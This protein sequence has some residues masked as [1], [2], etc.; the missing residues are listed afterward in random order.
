MKLSKIK[1]SEAI[2]KANLKIDAFDTELLLSFVKKVNRPYLYTHQNELL[3][4]EEKVYFFDLVQER[5]LKKPLAYLLGKKGFWKNDFYLD[6]SV[7]VPRPESE[8]LVEKI[9]EYDLK[10]KEL[11]ELGIGSGIISI[12]LGLENKELSVIGTDSSID[13]LMV[14][15]INSK[16]L[17]AENVIFLNH[18]WNNK[19]LF[20]K[21]DFIVS[22][23]PYVDKDKLIGNEDGIWFEPEKALFAEDE[24]MAD[25]KTIIFKSINFLKENGKLFLEHAPDQAKKV[26]K[27]AKK[28]GFTK[29]DQFSDYNGLARVSILG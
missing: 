29:I 23:P 12:S 24:G 8:I 17:N 25:L 18:D 7:L 27:E 22:N 13:A 2:S 28:V 14:A 9:L 10:G 15:N 5:E 4:L 16:K 3:T 6:S 11:L 20:P 21:M 19:W 1:I 26:A